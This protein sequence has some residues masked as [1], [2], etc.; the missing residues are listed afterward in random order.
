MK[1]T[2]TNDYRYKMYLRKLN[3]FTRYGKLDLDSYRDY[4]NSM[5]EHLELTKE[6]H[7]KYKGHDDKFMAKD[8][9]EKSPYDLSYFPEHV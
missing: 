8:I 5:M 1:D 7:A 6:F 9:L 2:N 3:K 4:L